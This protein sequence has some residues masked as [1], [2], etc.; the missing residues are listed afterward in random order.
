MAQHRALG[1]PRGA[2]GI[3]D[4]GEVVAA[5]RDRREALGRRARR[6]G[7]RAL[8]AL[9]QREHVGDAQPLRERLEPRQRARLRHHRARLGVL[10]EV[11]DL[12]FLV[13]AV[14]RQVHEAGAQ[15]AQVQQQRLGRL[16][17]LD[18]D[19]IAR[20]EAAAREKRRIACTAGFGLRIGQLPAAF[21]QQQGTRAIRGKAQIRRGCR[22]SRSWSG[23]GREPEPQLGIG[24]TRLDVFRGIRRGVVL[25][26]EDRRD[27]PRPAAPGRA[28]RAPC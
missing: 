22:G 25:L 14:E 5:S 24:N 17:D 7:K 4:R 3:E 21:Q 10:E 12:A 26:A 8:P 6:V 20:R 15:A 23:L 16:L 18:R 2:R 1:A 13:C 19:A 28:P 9:V 27:R 11:G